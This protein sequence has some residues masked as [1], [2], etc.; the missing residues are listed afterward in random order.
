MAK[1]VDKNTKIRLPVNFADALQPSV[2]QVSQNSVLMYEG[3]GVVMQLL[4]GA[5]TS[6]KEHDREMMILSLTAN[7]RELFLRSR[8]SLSVS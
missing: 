7:L 1:K 5:F 2:V 4:A 8:L 3:V 6:S